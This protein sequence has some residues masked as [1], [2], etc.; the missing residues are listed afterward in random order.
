V[1]AARLRHTIWR[2]VQVRCD[3][4]PEPLRWQ[5]PARHAGPAFG[6]AVRHRPGDN[7]RHGSGAGRGS[8]S[9]DPFPS[10]PGGRRCQRSTPARILRLHFSEHDHYRGRPLCETI[11]EKCRELHIAGAAVYRRLEGYGETA[12]VQQAPSAHAPSADWR[13]H[14]RLRRERCTPALCGRRDDAHGLDCGER[15]RGDSYP[16]IETQPMMEKILILHEA[17]KARRDRV[18]V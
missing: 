4:D 14:R 3:G 9:V 15:C 1:P 13:Q 8:H 10:A 7:G 2:L 17:R 5:V 12:E 16:A 11:V 6:P 18:A